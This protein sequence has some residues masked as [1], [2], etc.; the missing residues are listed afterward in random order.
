LAKITLYCTGE[1]NTVSCA[2]T[3]IGMLC[4]SKLKVLVL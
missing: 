4:G 1:R 3:G 2:V